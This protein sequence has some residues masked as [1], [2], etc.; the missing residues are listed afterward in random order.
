MNWWFRVNI[1]EVLTITTTMY[2]V[3][4]VLWLTKM[5]DYLEEREEQLDASS[6]E[7]T[8]DGGR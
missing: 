7:V 2:F 8:T 3:F 4:V 6:T 1:I 5:E